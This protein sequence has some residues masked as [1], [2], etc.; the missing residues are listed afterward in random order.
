MY[1]GMARNGALPQWLTSIHSEWASPYVAQLLCG[2][3]AMALATF[4]DVHMLASLLSIGC[5]RTT[6]WS[7]PALVDSALLTFS[8][9]PFSY[10]LSTYCEGS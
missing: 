2:G 1:L 8:V 3:V 9:F 4:F 5:E 7:P 6:C 10:N